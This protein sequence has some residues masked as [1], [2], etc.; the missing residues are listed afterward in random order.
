M[1]ILRTSD[2]ERYRLQSMFVATYFIIITLYF[3]HGPC[4]F[5]TYC[6]HLLLFIAIVEWL[7]TAIFWNMTPLSLVD[8]YHKRLSTYCVFI[9]SSILRLEVTSFSETFLPSLLQYRAIYVE[10]NPNI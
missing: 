10:R 7:T 9:H 2:F 6:H 8:G 3:Y 4:I 1:Y 5:A